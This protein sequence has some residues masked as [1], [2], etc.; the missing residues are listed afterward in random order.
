MKVLY[1]QD[2]PTVYSGESILSLILGRTTKSGSTG[3]NATEGA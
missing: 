2:P 3:S 1:C